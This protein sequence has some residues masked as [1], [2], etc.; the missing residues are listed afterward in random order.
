MPQQ[1]RRLVE[2]L[3][4]HIA[5]KEV[6][7]AVD[8][9]MVDQMSG[10]NK[11]LVTQVAFKRLLHLVGAAVTHEGILLL[12]AH[13]AEVTLEGPLFAVCAFMLAQI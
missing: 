9:L 12:E 11:A 4:T 5:L 8:M 7:N 13:L 1:L 10:L 6:L 2:A 3:L